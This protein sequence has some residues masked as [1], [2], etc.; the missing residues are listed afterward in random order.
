MRWTSWEIYA[1]RVQP[2]QLASPR[3]SAVAEAV[4]ASSL[5]GVHLTRH[6]WSNLAHCC[7]KRAINASGWNRK[8]HTHSEVIWNKVRAERFHGFRLSCTI[9]MQPTSS[10]VVSRWCSAWW[11][12]FY[13]FVSLAVICDRQLEREGEDGSRINLQ[14]RSAGALLSSRRL[15]ELL[16][17]QMWN[18]RR[19]RSTAKNPLTFCWTILTVSF[20]SVDII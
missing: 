20:W 11:A 5:L 18:L 17:R 6:H 12:I 3:I 2:H 13:L 9:D 1:Q 16:R 8:L 19:W 10:K 7:R 15:D 14:I 4:L